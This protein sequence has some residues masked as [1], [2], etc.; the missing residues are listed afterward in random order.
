MQEAIM[1][2]KLKLPTLVVGAALALLPTAGF[3]RDQDDYYRNR[4]EVMRHERHEARRMA[5]E[6][7]YQHG[8]Y[9]RWGYWHPYRY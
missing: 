5:R 8:Y 4:R 3:A 1:L 7:R 6:Y 9:D 2:N